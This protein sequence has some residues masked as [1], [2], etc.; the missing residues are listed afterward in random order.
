MG[1]E[2]SK[3]RKD[4]RTKGRESETS[5]MRKVDERLEGWEI[6]RFREWVVEGW[7]YE[8]GEGECRGRKDMCKI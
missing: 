5:R 2:L 7:G 4:E 6:G 8:R 1:R 3:G